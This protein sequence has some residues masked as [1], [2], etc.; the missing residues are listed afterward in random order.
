MVQTVIRLR[1]GREVHSLAYSPT[2]PEL[3]IG[4]SNGRIY[5]WNTQRG[6]QHATGD[7][8]RR[9]HRG[10]VQRRLGR[11]LNSR[12]AA[13]GRLPRRDQ[14][15]ARSRDGSDA[16]LAVPG[17]ARGCSETCC[18]PRTGNSSSATPARRRS[19]RPASQPCRASPARSPGATSRPPSGPVCCPAGRTS[20]SAPPLP[21][22][23]HPEARAVD[24][25]ALA[26]FRSPSRRRTPPSA[27]HPALHHG[28]ACGRWTRSAGR[29]ARRGCPRPAA[30][31]FWRGSPGW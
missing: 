16:R 2:A 23:R 6:T 29:T 18:S 15:A 8:D 31:R 21:V 30:R 11:V 4:S 12:Q 25:Q 14:R 9:D 7:T 10:R 3:A 5:L 17:R 13:R 19:G 26:T 24:G 20:T 28:G 1:R 22:P 27:K